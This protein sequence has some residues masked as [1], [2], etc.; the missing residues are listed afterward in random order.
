MTVR[1]LELISETSQNVHLLRTTDS[2]NQFFVFGMCYYTKCIFVRYRNG[3]A[4]QR[5]FLGGH[6]DGED[7][8]HLSASAHQHHV[9]VVYGGGMVR[10]VV[11][12]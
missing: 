10:G 8:L 6:N 4:S 1:K 5:E 9:Q 2:V 11:Y 3:R 7:V 12:N